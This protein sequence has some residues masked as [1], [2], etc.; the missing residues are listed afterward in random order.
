MRSTDSTGTRFGDERR[1]RLTATLTA[2]PKPYGNQSR[3][4]ADSGPST[5]VVHGRQHPLPIKRTP[6]SHGL[7]IRRSRVRIPEGPPHFDSKMPPNSHPA[8]P[9]F[10]GS[11]RN[12]DERDVTVRFDTS[13]TVKRRVPLMES[14]HHG[15]VSAQRNCL[16]G[17]IPFGTGL[18]LGNTLAE[19]AESGAADTVINVSRARQSQL[20]R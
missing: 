5:V 16:G 20:I 14:V 18:D 4:P 6:T 7:L 12:C 13:V 1:R 10:W 15:D 8:A 17:V 11:P 9:S 2:T 3:T 19:W